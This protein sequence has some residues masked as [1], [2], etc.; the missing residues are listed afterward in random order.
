MFSETDEIGHVYFLLG[1]PTNADYFP[2]YRN[3]IS[4]LRR[5]LANS[6]CEIIEEEESD[7][8]ALKLAR[9]AGSLN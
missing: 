4:F 1:R 5:R 2:A 6:R 7:Q 3:A 8:F 9:I